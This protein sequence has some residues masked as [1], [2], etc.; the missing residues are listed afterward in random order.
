MTSAR[1]RHA[2]G[3]CAAVA[4]ALLLAPGAHAASFGTHVPDGSVTRD[5][6]GT[7]TSP[8]LS[9]T[10]SGDLLLAYVTADGP[11]A[12]AQTASLAGGGLT[13]TLVRRANPRAGTSEIWKAIAPRPL[14]AATITSTLGAAGFD[15]TL[16]ISAFS[17]RADRA[18][19][20]PALASWRFDALLALAGEPA[21]E[22]TAAAAPAP[23]SFDDPLA[24]ASMTGVCPLRTALT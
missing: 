10:R 22:P 19:R 17:A 16:T 20:A 8:P 1:A 2:W 14:Q 15:Q 7:Q 5:G 12:G 11:V 23:V 13:W 3:A 24:V 6:R 9:T 4:A 21:P 18:L